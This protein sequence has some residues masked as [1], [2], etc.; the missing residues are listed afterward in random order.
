LVKK[1]ELNVLA[2][3]IEYLKKDFGFYYPGKLKHG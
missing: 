2:G 1:E 3:D